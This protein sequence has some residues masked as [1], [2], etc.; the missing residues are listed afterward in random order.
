MAGSAIRRE[1][2]VFPFCAFKS[3]IL[4]IYSMYDAREWHMKEVARR[5]VA[6]AAYRKISGQKS[7]SIY[8]YAAAGHTPMS[9]NYDYGASA[10]ISES[11]SGLYHYGLSAHISLKVNGDRFS[12][13]DYESSSHFS[14]TVRGRS[15]S[16]YDYGES[17]Y[18]NYSC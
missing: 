7:S 18:F 3:D 4:S 1:Q 14:G 10:H 11:S 12:G 17:G 2:N 13:Y 6:H 16:I 15:V 8:S 9:N 5:A